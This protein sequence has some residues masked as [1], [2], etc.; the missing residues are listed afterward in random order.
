MALEMLLQKKRLEAV[1][2]QT[3]ANSKPTKIGTPRP[4]VINI[5]QATKRT[6]PYMYVIV[7]VYT[8]CSEAKPRAEHVLTH[9]WWH[10][11]T[12]KLEKMVLAPNSDCLLVR[13]LGKWV[14]GRCP[15]IFIFYTIKEAHKQYSLL[16]TI[17]NYIFY[18]GPP[19]K[20]LYLSPQNP[21]HVGRLSR[22]TCS[23]FS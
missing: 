20:H 10:A 12:L 5:P 14:F 15:R 13:M 6:P 23:R 16:D 3:G 8:L 21:L 7:C 1:E 4:K 2:V 9:C 17:F 22:P 18:F 19:G 11:A